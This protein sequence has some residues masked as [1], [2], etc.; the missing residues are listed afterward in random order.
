M[1]GTALT[2]GLLVHHLGRDELEKLFDAL[3]AALMERQGSGSSL[4]DHSVSIDL[5]E[6]TIEISVTT[7]AATKREAVALAEFYVNDVIEAT[8]GLIRQEEPSV[9]GTRD[10]VVF[11]AAVTAKELVA[12]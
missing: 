3:G 9:V 5:R 11:D 4:K 2:L 7:E 12:V 6:S 10:T 1:Y 8:G